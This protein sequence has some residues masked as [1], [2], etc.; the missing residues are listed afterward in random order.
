MPVICEFYGILIRMFFA[1]RAPP[2]FH[3]EY[4]GHK[5][6]FDMKGNVTQGSFPP[7]AEKLVR[8]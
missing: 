1:D 6:V 5:A 2:H 4:A 7:R 3:A 8:E